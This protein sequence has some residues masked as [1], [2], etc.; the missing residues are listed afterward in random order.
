VLQDKLAEKATG[1]AD[2]GV[3]LGLRKKRRIYDLWKKVQVTQEEYR[4]HVRSCR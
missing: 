1:L 4:G 2:Q 3:L